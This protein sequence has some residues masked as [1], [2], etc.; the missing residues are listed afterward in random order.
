[1]KQRKP[2]VLLYSTYKSFEQEGDIQQQSTGN[3]QQQTDIHF[4]SSQA[5]KEKTSAIRTLKARALEYCSDQTLLAEK[6]NHLKMVFIKN[7]Y[8]ENTVW[9][10]LYQ[11]SR[12]KKNYELEFDKAL[13]VPYHP[14]EKRFDKNN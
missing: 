2:T 4:T 12:E 9:R 6:L 14:T 3:Q 5:W 11:E 8:P 13:F 1:M 7:G 10:I